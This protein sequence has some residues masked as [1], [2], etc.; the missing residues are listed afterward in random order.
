[1]DE[2]GEPATQTQNNNTNKPH[3]N[4]SLPLPSFSYHVLHTGHC[5]KHACT[6]TV[7]MMLHQWWGGG[8]EEGCVCVCGTPARHGTVAGRQPKGQQHE[9]ARC[10]SPSPSLFFHQH[11]HA[12]ATQITPAHL[13][14]PSPSLTLSLLLAWHRWNPC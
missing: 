10:V 8:E 14:I 3:T 13:L 6:C 11:G 1:M 9:Q 5:N 4:H 2:G 7:C 12:V